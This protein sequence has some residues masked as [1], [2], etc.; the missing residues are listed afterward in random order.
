MA[1]AAVDWERIEADYCAGVKSGRQIA[2]ECGRTEAAIRLK[3]KKLGW[4]RS[5]RVK[6]KAEAPKLRADEYSKA[7]FVYVIF[8]EDTAGKRIFKIGMTEF[9]GPRMQSHQCS[10][11]FDVRVACAFYVGNMRREEAYLHE[12]FSSKC[13]RGEWFDLSDEDVTFI[14]SRSKLT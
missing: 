10:S 2:R 4:I 3:A 12:V 7:G 5:D 9:F 1:R 8:V 11:P 13:V 6:E 14:S